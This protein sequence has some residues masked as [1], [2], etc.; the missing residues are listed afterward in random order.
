MVIL[1]EWGADL[2]MAQ[3]MPL[4]LIVSC[5]SKIQIGF[6][7]LV[8]AHPGGPR[9]RAV[10][11]LCVYSTVAAVWYSKK[12]HTHTRLTA[13][14]LGLPR[15]AGTRKVKPIWISLKQQ[16]VSGS[17]ISWAICKSASRSRQ[18]TTPAP[19]HSVFYRP[20]ALPAAQPTV[21]KHWRHWWYSKYT[22]MVNYGSVKDGFQKMSGY[23][24]SIKMYFRYHN[25]TV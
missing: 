15:W 6:T 12:K 10:K 5:F 21:S 24:S 7:F 25:C 3:L 11:R 22:I 8:P 4:P 19:H 14:F 16:T 17:G 1:L 20:D 2:P 18:M 13:L 9:Q 23:K